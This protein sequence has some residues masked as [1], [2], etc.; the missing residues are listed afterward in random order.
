M[1]IAGA[2]YH[3]AQCWLVCTPLLAIAP[4]FNSNFETCALAFFKSSKLLFNADAEPEFK[5][6]GIACY[7]LLCKGINLAM[8]W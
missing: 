4:V 1:C 2:V 7:H 5:Q 3:V 8:H 6:N